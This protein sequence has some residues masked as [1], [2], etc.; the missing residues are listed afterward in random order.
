MTDAAS[1]QIVSDPFPSGPTASTTSE[2]GAHANDAHEEAR[3]QVSSWPPPRVLKQ[4]PSDAGRYSVSNGKSERPAPRHDAHAQR[5]DGHH[6]GQTQHAKRD[7]L[8]KA[9]PDALASRAPEAIVEAPPDALAPAREETGLRRLP[10]HDLL[11]TG[12]DPGRDVK[13]QRLWLALQQKRKWNSLAVVP[14]GTQVS[15]TLVAASLAELAWQHRKRSTSVVDATEVTLPELEARLADMKAAVWTGDLAI[16]AL[17][18]FAGS[19]GSIA[20]AHAADAVLLCLALGDSG[21][22]DAEAVVDELGDEKVIGA[23]LVNAKGAL[24]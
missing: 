10:H 12:F 24:G 15:T 13:W 21:I 18:P 7:A 14:V 16:V 4:T 5:A 11:P 2:R 23:V 20:L 8:A 19:P 3:P 22:A 9:P 1:E 6:D 17:S